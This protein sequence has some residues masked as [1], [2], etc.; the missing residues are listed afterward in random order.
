MTIQRWTAIACFL[1]ATAVILGAF[2]AHGLKDRLDAYSLDVYQKAAFYHFI[3]ALGILILG[4]LAAQSSLTL[5]S[6]QK[7]A[8]LMC[9]GILLFSGSLYLLAITGVKWLGAITPLGGTAFIIGWI[10]A[11]VALLGAQKCH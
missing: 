11:G 9:I 1:L 5:V 2:G 3:H 4:V 10:W 7:I 6:Y 8:A